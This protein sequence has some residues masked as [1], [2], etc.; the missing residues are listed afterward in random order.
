MDTKS[1]EKSLVKLSNDTEKE[2]GIMTPQH[3]VE[4]LTLTVKIS[5]KIKW[6][7]YE[8]SDKILEQKESLL[9]SSMNFP[10]GLKAPG[11]EGELM[12]LKYA[13]LPEA[14]E[15]LLRSIEEYHSFFHS[16]PEAVTLH[17]RLGWLKFSEWEIFHLKHFKHHFEQ[18]RIW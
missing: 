11:S 17:P 15:N 10:K 13:N 2:F 16:Y 4:H 9:Y 5:Y 1:I 18:F 7:E 6:P 8:V 14:K 3:M 12:A